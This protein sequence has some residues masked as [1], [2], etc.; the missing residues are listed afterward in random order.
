MQVRFNINKR[1]FETMK[2]NRFPELAP[3]AG[4][5]NKD[6]GLPG[7]SF[8]TPPWVAAR[9]SKHTKE[10][11]SIV[12]M[13]RVPSGWPD[14]R[15]PFKSLGFW[16]TS[17]T[18]LFSG[19][20]GAYFLGHIAIDDDIKPHFIEVLRLIHLYTLAYTATHAVYSPHVVYTYMRS[21]VTTHYC[22]PTR[23]TQPTRG[24]TYYAFRALSYTAHIWHMQVPAQSQ[25]AG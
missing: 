10:V 15:T 19:D 18:L 3:T 13:L 12:K 11:D 24:H 8:P 23:S 9:G 14:L 2:M 17:E 4:K 6:T 7:Q 22:Q 1:S 5:I 25:H 21:H 16:K 20:L